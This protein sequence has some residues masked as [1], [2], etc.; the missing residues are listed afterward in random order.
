MD[1]L[2]LGCGY[3]GTDVGAIWKKKG[4]HVTVTIQKLDQVD[5]FF[6]SAQ[7]TVILKGTDP[8]E[9]IPLITSADLI[10]VEELNDLNT[11]KILRHLALETDLPRHLIFLSTIDVYGDHQ[12]Q[13]VDELSHL[14][15]SHEEAKQLI[16]IEKTYLSLQE[17]G[18]PICILRLAEVYG[19]G[20]ELSNRVK[21]IQGH[22]LPGFGN[23]IANMIHKQDCAEAIDYALRHHLEGVYNVSDDVHPTRKELFDL[24]ADK[25]TLP[26]VRWD[27]THSP[28]HLANKRISN[29]KI[30]SEGF[31]LRHPIRVLD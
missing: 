24:I 31:A 5:S 3:I 15:A 9:F 13:W 8:D 17:L 10:L 26:S 25:F 6:R 29:K 30:K 7:K 20:R 12:G 18:W 27:P 11:A 23:A 19:P 16:E 14:K 21:Q 4:H 2:I 22:T 1:I 28:L